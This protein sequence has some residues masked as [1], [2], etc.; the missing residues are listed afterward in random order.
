[1]GFII[2]LFRREPS[3]ASF[4]FL[5][6]FSSMGRQKFIIFVIFAVFVTTEQNVG[7]FSK[8]RGSVPSRIY[9][10]TLVKGLGT[11][12]EKSAD[13]TA[14]LAT[15]RYLVVFVVYYFIIFK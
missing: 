15:D 6:Y 13:Y 8:F 14:L 11:Y 7:I 2:S 4:A 12:S 9:L 3:I 1:M 5:C 10:V